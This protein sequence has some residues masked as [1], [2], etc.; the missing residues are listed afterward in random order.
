MCLVLGWTGLVVCWAIQGQSGS[1][2]FE[3]CHCFEALTPGTLVMPCEAA[4]SP[5]L[6]SL[7]VKLV[8]SHGLDLVPTTDH[9]DPTTLRD[10]DWWVLVSCELLL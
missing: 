5:E 7:R 6:L 9:E 8:R 2:A 1:D 4:R 3:V 10:T